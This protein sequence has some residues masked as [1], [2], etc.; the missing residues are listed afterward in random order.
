MSRPRNYTI[1]AILA[2]LVSLLDA[3]VALVLL[4]QGSSKINHSHSQPPYPAIV[5]V[6]IV[7]LIGLV[8]AYG[9]FRTQRWAVILTLVLMVLTVFIQLPGIAF[10][11]SAAQ[12]V[13]SVVGLLI[14]ASA[15]FYLLRRDTRVESKVALPA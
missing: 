1:A 13:T 6:L 12:V 9:V 7:G 3:I 2:A 11:S 4:P 5:V 8:A 10:G 15:I 14:G